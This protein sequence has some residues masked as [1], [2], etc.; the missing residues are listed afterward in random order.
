MECWVLG[1]GFVVGESPCVFQLK[2]AKEDTRSSACR[3]GGEQ[4]SCHG[5]FVLVPQSCP[6]PAKSNYLVFLLMNP[7]ESKAVFS[8][9]DRCSLTLAPL[10]FWGRGCQGVQKWLSWY[11]WAEVWNL[12][13]KKNLDIMKSAVFLAEEWKQPT[14]NPESQYWFCS[15]MCSALKLLWSAGSLSYI[16]RLSLDTGFYKV[17]ILTLSKCILLCSVLC[18]NHSQ[19]NPFSAMA[20]EVP[21]W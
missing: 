5:I 10:Y 11:G 19:R 13:R 3:A 4:H 21:E 16:Y 15:Y 12:S 14:N 7:Q 6:W 1:W 8:R 20:N 2:Q 18:A 17:C 9:P